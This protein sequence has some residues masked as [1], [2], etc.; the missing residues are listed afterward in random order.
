M[1]L[2]IFKK[3]QPEYE[4]IRAISVGKTGDYFVVGEFE[5]DLQIWN[6][7]GVFIQKFETDMVSG[8]SE[9]ISVSTDGKK[10]I[11]AG[12][13]KHTLTLFD[14]ESKNILWQR[15][16]LKKP[17]KVKFINDG[18]NS[19]FVDTENKGC[20]T[21]SSETGDSIEKLRG[22]KDFVESP[23]SNIIQIEKSSSTTIVEKKSDEVICKFNHKRQL[24]DSAF[25]EELLIC[26]YVGGPLEG[27]KFKTN[28]F[29]WSTNCKGH[30]LRVGFNLEINKILG[31]RWDFEKGGSKFL[32]FINPFTGIIEKEIDLQQPIC[33]EFINNG[34]YIITSQGKLYSTKDGS[35]VR[36]FDF[37]NN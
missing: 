24:L 9:S 6:L 3:K 7:S 18:L 12:Y 32:T 37:E 11:V 23:Y 31:I 19:V 21:L 14:I 22:I 29:L 26:S 28:E 33:V 1:I 34:E 36:E 16:D 4:K 35:I 10:L 17:Y 15:N 8:L 30:F 20:Y 2:K 27:I 5:K 13:D 25:S